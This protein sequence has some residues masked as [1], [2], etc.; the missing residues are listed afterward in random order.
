MILSRNGLVLL[1]NHYQY[2]WCVNTY[3]HSSVVMLTNISH[4]TKE[5]NVGYDQEL[6][7]HMNVSSRPTSDPWIVCILI[8]L[9]SEMCRRPE[10]T[11]KQRITFSH[12][13]I[14][15]V[16]TWPLSSHLTHPFITLPHHF[17]IDTIISIPTA[18][19]LTHLYLHVRVFSDY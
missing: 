17:I 15:I 5:S 4:T 13:H 6:S 7:N 2:L 1:L 10:S 11:I 18:C 3:I 8:L 16:V 19:L 12:H 9:T 14:I